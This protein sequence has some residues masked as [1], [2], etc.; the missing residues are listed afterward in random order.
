MVKNSG[1]TATRVVHQQVLGIICHVQMQKM[2]LTREQH[3]NKSC[4]L[5]SIEKDVVISGHEWELYGEKE[6]VAM[7]HGTITTNIGKAVIFS[8]S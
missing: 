7:I 1:S 3:Y 5:T 6:T 8:T 4:W 2:N